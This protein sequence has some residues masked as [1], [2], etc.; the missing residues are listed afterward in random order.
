VCTSF[1][2]FFCNKLKIKR[3]HELGLHEVDIHCRLTVHVNV[4]A[5]I[6][7]LYHVTEIL[8]LLT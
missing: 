5:K 7:Q 8:G 3:T 4:S 2:I 1:T 6:G